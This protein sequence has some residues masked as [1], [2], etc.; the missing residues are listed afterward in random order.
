MIAIQTKYLPP[1]DTKGSRIKAFTSNGHSLTRPFNYALSGE[2]LYKEVA[3]KLCK[4]MKWGTKLIGGS[5]KEGY[6]F[7][8]HP[9]L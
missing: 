5:T 1:T 3:V 2:E 8:F 7:V 9:C 4:K 6:T